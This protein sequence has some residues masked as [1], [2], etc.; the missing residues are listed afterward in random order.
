MEKRGG[1]EEGLVGRW[2]CGEKEERDGEV[3]R[4][5]RRKGGGGEDKDDRWVG[6]VA[7]MGG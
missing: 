7:L 4:C 5:C 2:G 6:K 1:R 3:K